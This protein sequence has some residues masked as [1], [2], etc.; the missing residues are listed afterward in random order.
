MSGVGEG[1]SHVGSRLVP[2]ESLLPRHRLVGVVKSEEGIEV[3]FPSGTRYGEIFFL[4]TLRVILSGDLDR[5]GFVCVL[6]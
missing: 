4:Q 6:G 3:P 1:F 5:G 2:C